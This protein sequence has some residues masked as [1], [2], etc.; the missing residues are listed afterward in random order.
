MRAAGANVI[1]AGRDTDGARAAY[2]DPGIGVE[3][4]DLTDEASIAALAER[5]G[6]VDHIVS[7]ASARA[8]GLLADLDR[9]AVLRSFDT[10]VLGP[11]MLA[12]Q[13]RDRIP[14]DGS[15][16]LFS[17]RRRVQDR[18]AACSRVA[19]TNG[20]VDTLDPLARRS[21]SRRSA[22]TRSRRA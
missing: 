3:R 18:A 15:F 17:R 4:V 9:E 13:F 20:A 1:D 21:S 11:L 14:P 7:T 16:V 12:K 6:A 8:R 22:S 2:A 5:V 19:I 10:K